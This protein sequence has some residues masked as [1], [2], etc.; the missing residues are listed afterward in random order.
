[1]FAPYVQFAF[2]AFSDQLL[3]APWLYMGYVGAWQEGTAASEN[4]KLSQY[5]VVGVTTYAFGVQDDFAGPVAAFLNNMNYVVVWA[6]F[7]TAAVKGVYTMLT[8]APGA[9]L[10]FTEQ[11]LVGRPKVV[12]LPQHSDLFVQ[13]PWRYPRS[14]RSPPLS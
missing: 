11:A 10:E 5:C 6:V 9:Q 12:V 7:F 3:G 1:M 2:G 8:R 13:S 14:P 4:R